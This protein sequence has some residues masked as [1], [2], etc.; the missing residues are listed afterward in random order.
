VVESTVKKEPGTHHKSLPDPRIEQIL[1]ALLKI[2][3]K[4][5]DIDLKVS[6]HRDEIDAIMLSV[7]MLGEEMH[8][9]TNQ[10]EASREQVVQSAKLASLGEMASGL[11]HELNNP[12]FILTGFMTQA[13]KVL[14][15][16]HP[17]AYL[18]VQ[19]H[20]QEVQNAADR[21]RKIIDHMRDFSRVARNELEVLD[22]NVVIKS[23]FSFFNQQLMLKNI[24]TQ[25]D[26]SESPVWVQ[27]DNIKMEQV[28]VNLLSNA[29]DAIE[30]KSPNHG[31]HIKIITLHEGDHALIQLK[32]DG[33]GMD[34]VTKS[35]IFDAFFTTK[36][37][38]KGT[39]LGLS[40]SYGIL[41]S[42]GAEIDCESVP[43]EGTQFSIRIPT[44]QQHE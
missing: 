29:K 2:A 21:I 15:K 40:V 41:R 9:Y 35:K 44:A 1:N 23:A 17:E 3:G 30:K 42:F 38:G 20:V 28:F 24:E 18:A 36:E 26:L 34:S 5:F 33:C 25:F 8:S 27:V 31:G 39:G 16:N 12:L 32:D 43:M 10:L 13:L 6:E 4:D 14:V 22:L 37:V 19:D 7:N 11:S